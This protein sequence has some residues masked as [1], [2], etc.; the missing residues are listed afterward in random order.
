MATFSADFGRLNL[1]LNAA[2]GVTNGDSFA[3]VGKGR[4]DIAW[5]KIIGGSGSFSALTTKLQASLD[6]TNWDDL[7]SDT[8]TA[9]DNYRSIVAECPLYL[10]VIVSA[11]TV[12]SG[13]PT[14]TANIL[15]RKSE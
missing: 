2:T 1:S 14:V 4:V 5:Q 6:N 9:S 11:A 13:T 3:L 12:A 7:D 15:V 8:A 10:R